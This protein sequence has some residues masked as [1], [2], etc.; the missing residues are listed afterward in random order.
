MRTFITVSL[1][2]R[3]RRDTD[4]P[5]LNAS[6]TSVFFAPACQRLNCIYHKEG[7]M[8]RLACI[9]TNFITDWLMEGVQELDGIELTAVYSRTMEKGKEFADKY[10]AKKVY[11]NF[12]ELAKDPDIDAV[13]VASPTYCHFKHTMMM[14][15][16]K[17][18]VLCEKPVASNL[19]EL[20][21]MVKAAKDNQV[22]FMEAMKSVHT[23][24]YKAMMEHL[25]KLGAI[26]RAT[27]QYCQY[28]SRYD[29]FK[30]GII[31]NAFKPE[32]SNGAVM[33]IGVYC[34]HFLAALFGMPEKILADAVFLENGVDGAGTI[35]ASYGD[36]QAEVIYSKITNSKLPTQI[37][38]EKG[39]M[40][41][42]E[43]PNPQEIKILYN[44]G[45]EEILEFE[46]RENP[47]KYETET[48]LELIGTNQADHPYLEASVIEMKI[49]DE[50]RRQTGIVFPADKI[51]EQ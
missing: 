37:Q 6:G 10:G 34:V 39:C 18:H 7:I 28:S 2:Q 25:P 8:V 30:M 22:I 46:S 19:T 27:I 20:E 35:I 17:K 42:S 32:L 12:E 3:T 26:R 16:H 24:G 21:L 38:G 40:I 51:R 45:T 13:Y 1:K 9:G 4:L 15:N 43:C 5:V 14:L 11:D 48:F 47:M 36:K 29:K 44:D 33:D 23:P 31:E 49:I 41:I 50:A